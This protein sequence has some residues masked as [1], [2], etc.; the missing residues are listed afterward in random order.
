MDFRK[1]FDRILTNGDHV[2]VTKF[3][4]ILLNVLS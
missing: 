3:L 1:S 4:P 2:I